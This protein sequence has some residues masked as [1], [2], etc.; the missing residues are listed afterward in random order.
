MKAYEADD[1]SKHD[2]SRGLL[3]LSRDQGT[4]TD[5]D[6]SAEQDAADQVRDIAAIAVFAGIRLTDATYLRIEDVRDSDGRVFLRVLGDERD[7]QIVV[8]PA[9]LAAV[10]R[11]RTLAAR[12]A[13]RHRLFEPLAGGPFDPADV[14][15][16]ILDM[17]DP[18]GDM[19]R[20]ITV[21]S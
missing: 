3:T 7:V 20:A 9:R 18:D 21:V 11:S 10:V 16:R 14:L 4:P 1:A 8:V 2:S 6:R 17:L 5:P 12:A 13:G 19:Y 15:L